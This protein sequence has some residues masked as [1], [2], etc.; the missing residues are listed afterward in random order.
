MGPFPIFEVDGFD[1]LIGVSRMAY[2]IACC[3]MWGPPF[4]QVKKIVSNN[5]NMADVDRQDVLAFLEG[6]EVS[7]HATSICCYVPRISSCI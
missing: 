2:V 1:L 6:K 5:D 7:M 3:R 4:R